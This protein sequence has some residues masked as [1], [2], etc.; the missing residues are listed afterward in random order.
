MCKRKGFTLVEL[1]VVIAII[2]LLMSILI[3]ALNRA[4]KQANSV[5][6]RMSLHQWSLIWSLYCE[7]NDDKFPEAG[8]FGWKRGTWIIALR[9]GWET[10]SDILR[11]PTAVKRR[12]SL[13]GN[14]V[15][16]GGPSNTYVMGK[17][18]GGPAGEECSYSSNNWVYYPRAGQTAIQGRPTASN[19]KV[20]TVSGGNNI[21]IF[22]D[23]MWR[24]GGPSEQGKAGNPPGTD[25]EWDGFS[26]EMKHFCIDRHETRVNWLFLDWSV[27]QVRLKELWTLKWN[28]DF[29]IA[30]PW[31]KAGNVI[32][33]DWP[34][35]M[36]KFKDF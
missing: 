13:I 6:C 2:A 1:L 17:T 8:G 23:A 31:T 14:L 32:P 4:R 12:Y 29:N 3:P 36:Q 30:G 24:G 27:R 28:R 10:R 15:D 21:P 20:K 26:A 9:A 11:C 5:A 7:E 19:W 35:W 34:D 33:R 18:P 16:W 22:G 25:G